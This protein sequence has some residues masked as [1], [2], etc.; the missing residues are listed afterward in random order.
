[1]QRFPV[2]E[3]LT[4]KLQSFM[5]CW[6]KLFG[7]GSQRASC[8]RAAPPCR[9]R[10]RLQ[11]EQLENRVV[12]TVEFHNVFGP[13]TVEPGHLQH[14]LQSPEVFFVFWGS[15]WS[16]I[17]GAAYEAQ[18]VDTAKSVINS[19]YLQGMIQYGGDGLST[20]GAA[21][22]DPSDPPPAHD[23]DPKNGGLQKVSDEIQKAIDDPS[24]P[25][26]GPPS[27]SHT[28]IYAVGPRPVQQV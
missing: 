18:L 6:Q 26:I 16:T 14:A 3:M 22:T 27:R 10:A 4:M 20:F 1:M 13:E 25:I 15:Y 23:L 24:S 5:T 2:Q 21:W 12:P 11:L 19:S 17:D 7:Q 8:R 28:P 9:P